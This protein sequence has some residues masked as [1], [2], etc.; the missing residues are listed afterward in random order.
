M[1]SFYSDKFYEQTLLISKCEHLGIAFTFIVLQILYLFIFISSD[2]TLL[3]IMC[4]IALVFLVQITTY[5]PHRSKKFL[6]RK[7]R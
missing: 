6:A 7:G 4:V 3:P 2:L 5:R 1:K